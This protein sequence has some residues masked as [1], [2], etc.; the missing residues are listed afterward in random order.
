MKCFNCGHSVQP[1]IEKCGNCNISVKHYGL[2]P[3]TIEKNEKEVTPEE[4]QCSN[5][6]GVQ[7]DPQA[8][9]CQFCNFPFANEESREEKSPGEQN[10][11]RGE[12]GQNDH[13][14]NSSAFFDQKIFN[15]NTKGYKNRIL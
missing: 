10:F 13:N 14:D 4:K 5:C 9:N 8:V 3:E 2:L 15:L 6:N 12:A 1:E 11:A 7:S